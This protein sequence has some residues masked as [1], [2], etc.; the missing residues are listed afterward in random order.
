MQRMKLKKSVSVFMG[1]FYGM[2]I[3]YEME[4]FKQSKTLV[5]KLK[6]K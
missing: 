2:G 6:K 3:F 4:M 1:I 5:S